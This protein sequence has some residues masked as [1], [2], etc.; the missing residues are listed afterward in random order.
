MA[1]DRFH[2]RIDDISRLDLKENQMVQ[3]YFGDI[4]LNRV[5]FQSAL[6]AHHN[7]V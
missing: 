4:R 1:G 6:T 7:E 5:S 3:F 2:A